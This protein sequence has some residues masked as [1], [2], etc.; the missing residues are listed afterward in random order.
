MAGYA[1]LMELDALKSKWQ[2][3]ITTLGA[4]MMLR[5]PLAAEVAALAGYDYVC[6]DAQHGLVDE[7]TVIEMVQAVSRTEAVPLVRVAFNEP[8]LIGRA[9]DAGAFGVIV[10]MVNSAAEAAAAVAACRYAPEGNRSVGP[11]LNGNRHGMGY[12]AAAN[13]SVA[14]IVMIETRQAVEQIEE[15]VSVPGVDAVYVGPADLSMSLGLP[16]GPDNADPS[17]QQ[18]LRDIVAACNRHGVVPGVHASAVLAAERYEMGFRMITVGFDS[19]AM[20][21]ALRADLRTAQ[22]VTATGNAPADH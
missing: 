10:P 18:A 9:L 11:V 5:E 19:T 21:A 13:A 2:S 15:I 12:I 4:W 22:A 6:V 17:F 3:G 8:W 1:R 20:F 16:P 14:C 7:H